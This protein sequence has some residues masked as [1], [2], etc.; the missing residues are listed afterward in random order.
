LLY[1]LGN[2]Q[3]GIQALRKLLE[4]ILP[5]VTVL[6]D[7]EVT[8][9]F[10]Q[11]GWRTM[12]LNARRIFSE[13]DQSELILLAIEDITDCQPQDRADTSTEETPPNHSGG[14]Q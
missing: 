5:H 7:F 6:N 10:E 2:G 14:A 4:E 8:H 11:I 3:W 1:D 13:E 9:E 12:R